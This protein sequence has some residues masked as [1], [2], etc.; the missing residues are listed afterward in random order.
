MLHST[1]KCPYI[2]AVKLFQHIES[3]RSPSPPDSSIAKRT[4]RDKADKM[5]NSYEY[6]EHTKP[7]EEGDTGILHPFHH[8]QR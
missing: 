2:C 3:R 1:Y 4:R 7:D 8:P 6:R 5:N